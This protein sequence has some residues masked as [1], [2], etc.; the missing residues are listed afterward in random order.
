MDNSDGPEWEAQMIDQ[1]LQSK[2]CSLWLNWD[3]TDKNERAE[4]VAYVQRLFN[5]FGD[6]VTEVTSLSS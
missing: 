3:I 2:G 1:W 5:E 6:Y 4:A